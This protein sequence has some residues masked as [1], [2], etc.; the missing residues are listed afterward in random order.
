[1]HIYM[2]YVCVKIH[3]KDGDVGIAYYVVWSNINYAI[4]YSI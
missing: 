4:L 1:M 2:L 3:Q